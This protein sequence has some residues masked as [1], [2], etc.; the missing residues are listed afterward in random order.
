ML[1]TTGRRDVT[2][3]AGDSDRTYVIRSVDEPTVEL[4]KHN[5]VLL[6]RGPYT[7]ETEL[8]L[9]ERYDIDLLVSKD[10]GGP[11]TYP[12]LVAARRRQI[13]VVMVERPALPIEGADQVDSVE[14][15]R[16]WCI[17]REQEAKGA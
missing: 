6:D 7:V 13:P 17:D 11:M 8:G 9:L 10:S 2:A 12:K 16:Q 15:A 5:V 14:T 3:F 4:P 1:L